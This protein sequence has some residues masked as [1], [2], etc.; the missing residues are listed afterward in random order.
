VNQVNVYVMTWAEWQT[1]YAN[2]EVPGNKS[3]RSLADVLGGQNEGS[4]F[5][6]VE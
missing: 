1:L 3:D 2:S 4:K 5:C 6:E